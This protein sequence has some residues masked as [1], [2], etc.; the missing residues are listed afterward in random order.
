M[1]SVYYSVTVQSSTIFSNKDRKY[2]SRCKI[3]DLIYRFTKSVNLDL[4]NY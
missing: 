1:N 2:C 4:T 3:L